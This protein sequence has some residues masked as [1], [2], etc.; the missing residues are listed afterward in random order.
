MEIQSISVVKTDEGRVVTVAAVLKGSADLEAEDLVALSD[1][2]LSGAAKK[3]KEEKPARQS[4]APKEEKPAEE[5]PGR[6]APP[7]P[8][9]GVSDAD[10]A[11]AASHAADVL[12]KDHVKDL[13]K[14]E[15]K[16][17]NVADIKQ[18]DRADFL[19]WL[20]EDIAKAKPVEEETTRR[21]RG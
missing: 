15:L 3:P 5:K 7:E 17:T 1:A 2:I 9:D 20:S 8:E 19:R 13:L 14:A 12:G 6:R 10:L 21:R 11:K 4:R 16:V 18:E